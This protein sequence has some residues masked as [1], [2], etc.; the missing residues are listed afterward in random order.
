[1][2]PVFVPAS[3]VKAFSH[4]VRYVFESVRHLPTRATAMPVAADCGATLPMELAGVLAVS[5]ESA[6]PGAAATGDGG[7]ATDVPPSDAKMS[8]TPSPHRCRH[9][10]F[11]A[12]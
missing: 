9:A 2:A 4:L 6:G 8:S 12:G 5:D 10:A 7:A 11:S 3:A 1:M